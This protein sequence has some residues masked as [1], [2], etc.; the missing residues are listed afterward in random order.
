MSRTLNDILFH[1]TGLGN[2]GHPGDDVL[3]KVVRVAANGLGWNA[4]RVEKEL[5][6]AEEALRLP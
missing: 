3:K 4:A 2:V 1:R 6:R 5:A